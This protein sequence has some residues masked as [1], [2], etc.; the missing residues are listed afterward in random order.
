[1]ND[2][3]GPQRVGMVTYRRLDD[4]PVFAARWA[5]EHRGEH[6]FFPLSP[7]Q[8]LDPLCRVMPRRLFPHLFLDDLNS[9]IGRTPL[10][11]GIAFDAFV[12]RQAQP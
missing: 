11:A 4:L 6:A 2:S 8:G 7:T 5:L 12:H 10:K 1:M 3:P 9:Q